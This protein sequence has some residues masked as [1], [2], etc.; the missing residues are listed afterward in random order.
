MFTY[1]CLALGFLGL[2]LAV[3]VDAKPDG[4]MLGDVLVKRWSVI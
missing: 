2:R 3:L 1:T 4:N